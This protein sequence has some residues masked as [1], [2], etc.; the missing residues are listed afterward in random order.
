MHRAPP[1][2]DDFTIPS[3]PPGRHRTPPTWEKTPRAQSHTSKGRHRS[4]RSRWPVILAVLLSVAVAGVT[5]HTLYEAGPGL[6]SF[7]DQAEPPLVRYVPPAVPD[8]T[9]ADR[10]GIARGANREIAHAIRVRARQHAR[11]LREAARDR[12]QRRA[13][14]AP[15]PVPATAP[16]APV[17]NPGSFSSFEACVISRESGGNPQA[18]NTTSGA[19]GLFQ[20]LPSTWASLN[21]GYPGGAQT[22]PVS[23]QE[24]GFSILYARDGTSPW[25]PYDGCL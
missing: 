23:V 17:V 13:R 25:Q 24:E 14:L 20:F 12:R 7:T 6:S 2:W 21:L 19:G 22:A 3:R 15:V 4:P 9:A 1:A 16:P 18:Y 8:T 10:A 5:A 11:A